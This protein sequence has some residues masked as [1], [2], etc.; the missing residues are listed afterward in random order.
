MA[1]SS[2]AP[3]ATL[4][5][6]IPSSRIHSRAVVKYREYRI[7]VSTGEANW[8]VWRRFSDFIALREV[9]SPGLRAARAALPP[10]NFSRHALSEASAAARLPVLEAWLLAVV[11]SDEAA[12]SPALLVFLGLASTLPARRNLHVRTIMQGTSGES[13][14][15]VLFRTKGARHN[16]HVPTL[17]RAVLGSSW[18][19]VGI[20]I[21]RDDR[22]RVCRA[23]DSDETFGDCGVLE[24]DAAGTRFYRLRDYEQEWHKQYEEIALRPLL[25]AG[26]GSVEACAVLQEWYAEVLGAPYQLSIK[27]V[28]EGRRK[29]KTT[30]PTPAAAADAPAAADEEEDDDDEEEEPVRGF[31]CSEL[32][33]YCYQALGVLPQER[34]AA[35]YYP[36]H[37]G[38]EEDKRRPLPLVGGAKFGD[39]VSIEFKT[40]A[41]DAIS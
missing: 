28:I 4:S 8:I 25:W 39:E 22:R 32:A 3:R 24:C 10:K 23:C 16:R 15:L 40:P 29:E 19:H 38:E 37:F 17:Q 13:G 12:A 21:F 11:A 7:E 9:L 27:K 2:I 36:V 35:S 5:V 33:A 1:S 20:L 31:F 41:I 6:S 34:A 14:D 26:R 30:P 18:D